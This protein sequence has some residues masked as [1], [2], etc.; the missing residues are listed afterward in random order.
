MACSLALVPAGPLV[1]HAFKCFAAPP[2]LREDRSLLLRH[3]ES[4][5]PP[6]AVILE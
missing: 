4:A 3:G 1:Q 5:E 6:T 2:G